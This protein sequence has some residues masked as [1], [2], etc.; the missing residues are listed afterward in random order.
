MR[1]FVL[2]IKLYR[3]IRMEMA[4]CTFTHVR[5]ICIGPS[6]RICLWNVPAADGSVTA[7]D[8]LNIQ[9]LIKLLLVSF[10]SNTMSTIR[11][12]VPIALVYG[13]MP[14]KLSTRYAKVYG[15]FDGV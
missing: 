2:G 14:N 7:R 3:P 15:T 13:E 12:R 9:L 1:L 5:C 4:K 10:P 6:E 8:E 11:L